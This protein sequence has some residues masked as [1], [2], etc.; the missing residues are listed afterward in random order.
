MIMGQ[1]VGIRK[2][3]GSNNLEVLWVI[4]KSFIYMMG[5]AALIAT[6]LAWFVGKMLLQNIYSRI[7]LKPG[8]FITG[9]LFLLTI[10]VF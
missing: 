4:S 2:V 5:L 7:A 10:K 9:I 3:V 6:P 8:F 1:E